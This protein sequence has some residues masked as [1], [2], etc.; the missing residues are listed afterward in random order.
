MHILIS[1][2]K[3]KGSLSATKVA[4]ALKR[5]ILK[6]HPNAKIEIQAMADGG[7]GSLEL[8]N[9][10]WNLKKHEVEVNDPLLE[11]TRRITSLRKT[12]L[13]LNCLLL[14]VLPLLKDS[15]KNP[16]KTSTFG[17]GELILDAFKK[18]FKKI[19]LFIGG[20]C[21][22]D[23]AI[24]IA[25]AIGYKFTDANGDE[26][27]PIGE[28][29]IH[30]SRIRSSELVH[31]IRELEINVICD[32]SNP[33]Y[34]PNG[35]AKVYAQQKGATEEMIEALDKGLENISEVFLATFGVDVQQIAGSGAAG[36]VGGG[37]IAFLD[38]NK[39]SGTQLFMH[40]FNLDEKINEADLVITG[41]GGFDRQ[42]LQG[43]VVGGIE[44]Y[45]RGYQKPLFVVAG[46]SDLKV[47][48]LEETAIEK[49]E[50]LAAKAN[51]LEDAVTNAE[52]YLE[53]IGEKLLDS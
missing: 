21:T 6:S 1:P 42:S 37:M 4:E 35:A 18:G 34:G 24:G 53:E 7:D 28:N 47:S 45:C 19:N 14:Q 11:N 22:N 38:A 48:D 20:S 46:Q 16:F 23:A 25:A 52:K 26:L 10:L 41:E 33:F 44:A 39:V 40:L 31:K 49:I 15:E 17:T 30:I 43:K 2:D 5:G 50:T 13:L 32:V 51:S 36:G 12:Q 27:E 29:L 9:S 3:F 8:L